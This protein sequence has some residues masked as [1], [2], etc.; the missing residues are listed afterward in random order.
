MGKRKFYVVWNGRQTG[1]F[2]SWAEC[3]AQVKGF[4]R[5]QYKSYP[6]LE[7][8]EA[9]FSAGAPADYYA[10]KKHAPSSSGLVNP[11][12]YRTDTVLPLPLSVVAKAWAVDAACSGNPG[13]MEYRGVDLQTGTEIFHVGPMYGT[14]NIGE[15]LAIVHAVALL[16]QQERRLTVYSDSRNAMLWFKAG[17]CRTKLKETSKSKE[18]LGLVARAEQWLQ[19]H[20][21][22]IQVKKWKTEEWGEIPADFGRK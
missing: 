8:A 2:A 20:E 21:H 9:A 13:K 4:E 1:V 14:N 19:T 5:P 11:P 3:E 16:T 7:E 22:H 10:P 6:T 15:F 12:D 18:V 17:K